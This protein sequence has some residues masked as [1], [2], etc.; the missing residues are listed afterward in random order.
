MDK[1]ADYPFAGAIV[2][3][4]RGETLGLGV[5]VEMERIE[6][7]TRSPYDGIGRAGDAVPAA[8]LEV[9]CEVALRAHPP[10]NLRKG[11]LPC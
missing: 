4:H 11:V 3:G 2:Y 8:R 7:P 1:C 10:Y 9:S 5:E 6:Q